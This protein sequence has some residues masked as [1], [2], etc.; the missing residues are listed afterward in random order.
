MGYVDRT[1]GTNERILCRAWFPIAYWMGIWAALLV[2]GLTV[3]IA[4]LA[5]PAAQWHWAIW[6]CV[7][8]LPFGAWVFATRG[9]TMMSTEIAVTTN[10]VVV[11]RGIFRTQTDEVAIPNIETVQM[12]QGLS[13]VAMGIASFT[14]E[15]TGDDRVQIPPIAWPFLFRKAIE[16][17]RGLRAGAQPP[18]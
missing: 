15:G 1:L 12:H 18:R 8:A 7:A 3:A 10:R 16:D 5:A 13:G 14:I 11:K 9:W 17:A 6:G 2:P 4:A